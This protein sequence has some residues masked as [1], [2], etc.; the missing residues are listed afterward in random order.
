[1]V[2][3]SKCCLVTPPNFLH[4][5]LI[6]HMSRE[7]DMTFQRCATTCKW[8]VCPSPSTRRSVWV[9]SLHSP[10]ISP[11][12][13][14]QSEPLPPL[15]PQVNGQWRGGA[16]DIGLLRAICNSSSGL[17]R[18]TDGMNHGVN[19]SWRMLLDACW[20][21]RCCGC[22]RWQFSE[23]QTLDG[24][25]N[26]QLSNLQTWITGKCKFLKKSVLSNN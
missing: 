5:S 1:M 18:A 7:R 6:L 13:Y 24:Q 4:L 14:R 25:H 3:W 22:P 15:P 26:N 19:W 20:A 16:A 23:E 21:E 10:L 11:P 8:S 17:V 2:S 9:D 12:S